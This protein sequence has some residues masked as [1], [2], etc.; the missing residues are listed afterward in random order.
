MVEVTLKLEEVRE[1]RGLTRKQLGRLMGVSRTAIYM[2]E[3]GKN[4]MT[5]DRLAK[6][7]EVLGVKVC[8]LFDERTVK[9]G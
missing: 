6:A 2:W 3:L 9:A 8:E 5:L 1:R 7:A 4:S